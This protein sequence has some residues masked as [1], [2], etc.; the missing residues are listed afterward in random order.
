MKKFI[1]GIRAYHK[2]KR[3]SLKKVNARHKNIK[4]FYYDGTGKRYVEQQEKIYRKDF[5]DKD[6]KTEQ[7]ISPDT[8]KRKSQWLWKF[9]K[10]ETDVQRVIP[11]IK[12]IA[13]DGVLF[14]HTK[15]DGTK[16]EVY[17]EVINIEMIDNIYRIGKT[18]FD[19]MKG[20]G[21]FSLYFSLKLLAKGMSS[22]S[23]S[24]TLDMS[25]NEAFNTELIDTLIDDVNI[26]EENNKVCYE[27]KD[28]T[29]VLIESVLF[30]IVGEY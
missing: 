2:G 8:F 19:I 5:L 29:T 11:K 17:E 4:L 22:L 18:V 16:Q 30:R 27:S 14:A 7:E 20:K 23:F 15:K 25:T 1:K 10:P 28:G 6:I 24:Q 3:I 26:K 21:I 9:E 13:L 12:T